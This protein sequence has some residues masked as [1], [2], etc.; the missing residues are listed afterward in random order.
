MSRENLSADSAQNIFILVL[1]SSPK[2]EECVIVFFA[3]IL[4]SVLI[5]YKIIIYLT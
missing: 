2:F 3:R 1:S 5:I 4:A